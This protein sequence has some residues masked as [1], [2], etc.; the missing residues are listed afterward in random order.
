[1]MPQPMMM[2]NNN[3]AGAGYNPDY[4]EYDDELPEGEV[5]ERVILSNDPIPVEIGVV[6][7]IGTRKVNAGFGGA[8]GGDEGYQDWEDDEDDARIEEFLSS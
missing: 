3:A 5:G 4:F 6:K 2:M 8:R 1:M 7:T